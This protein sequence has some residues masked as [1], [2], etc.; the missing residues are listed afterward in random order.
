M[1]DAY[2]TNYNRHANMT[3]QEDEKLQTKIK[4]I[5]DHFLI[6]DTKEIKRFSHAMTIIE[7]ELEKWQ[8]SGNASWTFK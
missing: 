6:K 8:A 7:Q 5:F 4:K 3:L 1:E 2:T